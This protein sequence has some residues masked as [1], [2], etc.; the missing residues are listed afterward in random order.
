M[1]YV[2]LFFH[3]LNSCF[4]FVVISVNAFSFASFVFNN[5]NSIKLAKSEDSWIPSIKYFTTVS[6]NR[7]DLK[8]KATRI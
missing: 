3:L 4:D 2:H 7:F 6:S 8:E 5:Y 1:L